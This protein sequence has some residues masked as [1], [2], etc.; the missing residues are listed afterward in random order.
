MIRFAGLIAIVLVAVSLL[1]HFGT[2]EI[3]STPLKL[4]SDALIQLANSVKEGVDTP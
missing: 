1:D 4:F 3:T 2:I